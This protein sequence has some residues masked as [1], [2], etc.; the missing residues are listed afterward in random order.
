M[1]RWAVRVGVALLLAIIFGG[2]LLIFRLLFVPERA[3]S[4]ETV[5]VAPV[6]V[7]E[8]GSPSQCDPQ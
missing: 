4:R 2:F 7:L 3:V 8:T 5:H 1:R 6:P